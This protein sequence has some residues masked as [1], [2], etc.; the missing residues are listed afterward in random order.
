MPVC[1]CCLVLMRVMFLLPVKAEQALHL[2]ETR[3]SDGSSLYAP[4]GYVK[5]CYTD[6]CVTPRNAALAPAARAS[7]QLCVRRW[8][9]RRRVPNRVVW[10]ELVIN[11][12]AM[13]CSP[14]ATRSNRWS[15]RGRKSTAAWVAAPVCGGFHP[16]LDHTFGRTPRLGQP[17]PRVRRKKQRNKKQPVNS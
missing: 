11:N 17:S 13:A 12:V 4:I 10:A 9:K 3:V 5:S 2:L 16:H 15:K 14:T 7:L 1:G 6:I 8:D